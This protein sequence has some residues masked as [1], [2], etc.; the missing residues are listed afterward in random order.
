MTGSSIWIIV[1]LLLM[2]DLRGVAKYTDEQGGYNFWL[3]WLILGTYFICNFLFGATGP[4]RE[5]S[6]ATKYACFLCDS[7]VPTD[8]DGDYL[9]RAN[10]VFF[11]RKMRGKE[12]FSSVNNDQEKHLCRIF[13]VPL[14][15]LEF[16]E[17]IIIIK[18]IIKEKQYTHTHP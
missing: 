2:I 13:L 9:R 14:F 7:S 6:S 3:L 8:R 18:I 15:L 4:D 5:S 16:P 12:K 10:V 1:D 11:P 17:L